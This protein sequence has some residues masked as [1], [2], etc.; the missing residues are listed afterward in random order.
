VNETPRKASTAPRA[1]GKLTR[2]LLTL[3]KGTRGR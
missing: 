1:V 3:S 2:R